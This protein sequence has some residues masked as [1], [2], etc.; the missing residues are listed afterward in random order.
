[1]R[2]VHLLEYHFQTEM[3]NLKNLMMGDVVEKVKGNIEEGVE[4]EVT[5]ETNQTKNNLA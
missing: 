1:M 3:M 4:T 2:Q 5:K